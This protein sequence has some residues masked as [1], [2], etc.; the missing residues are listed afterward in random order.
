MGIILLSQITKK[1]HKQCVEF[2]SA[3]HYCVTLLKMI[4]DFKR[5]DIAL[6]FKMN[7]IA[8]Q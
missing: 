4:G 2:G 3:K 8:N 5:Y 6:A 1:V 7:L